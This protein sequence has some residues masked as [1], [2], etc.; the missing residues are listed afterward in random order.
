[1]VEQAQAGKASI[2][3]LADR[4][5]A[6]FVPT[7]LAC[8]A[9]TLAGWLLAG[10]PREPRLQRRP[11]RAD[12]RLPVRAGPRHPRRPGG[13]PPGAA[14]SSA[15]SSRA[16][17]RWSPP[18]PSTPI[19]L[20]KTGTIT[21]GQM[22]VTGVQTVPGTS[23]ADLLRYAGVGR[24]GLRTRRGR[25]HH[26]RWPPPRRPR[27]PSAD[28]FAALPGLGARGIVEGHQVILGRAQL[29]ADLGVEVAPGLACWCRSQEEAGCTTVLV[30]WDDQIRGA[31]A[32]TDTVEALRPRRRP[33]RCAPWACAPSC[34]PATT[35]PPPTPSRPPPESTRSSA[36]PSR[37]PRPSSSSACKRAGRPVAMVGDGVNDAPRPGRRPARPGPRHRHRRRHLRRRHD[38]APRRPARPSPTPSAWPAPRSGPSAATWP[39]PSATTWP[40]PAAG[41]PR[42]PQPPDRRRHH[43][44][45]LGLRRLEQPPP[46]PLPFLASASVSRDRS[47]RGERTMGRFT[48][49]GTH[50]YRS[51]VTSDPWECARA[52]LQRRGGPA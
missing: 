7:V 5:C 36:A 45:V 28:D 37:R 3:R 12:H 22:T 8:S 27:W 46:A 44:A 40:G 38:P 50:G 49:H 35:P 47:F 43:D 20:D 18:A 19:V 34:S 24:G 31:L 21:T 41:R 39:G 52:W 30:S 16:T 9:L 14:P 48:H 1:M 13:R 15:S 4:I 6:V 51:K 29:F 11:G 42:L 17:R 23:R 32:V 26:R 33:P 10:Q 25:R 2:Q